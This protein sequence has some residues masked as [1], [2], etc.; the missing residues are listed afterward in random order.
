MSSLPFFVREKCCDTTSL[1][2]SFDPA[3]KSSLA[4]ALLRMIPTKGKVLI[5]SIPTPEIMLGASERRLTRPLLQDGLDSRHVNLSSL[6]TSITIVS[7]SLLCF[8]QL[9]ADSCFRSLPDP[10]RSVSPR[11][12]VASQFPSA[13][14]VLSRIRSILLSGS[15]RYN[16]S[17]SAVMSLSLWS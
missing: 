15:L 6:R 12:P 16:V 13:H 10:S 1:F 14:H 17:L 3:G 5:V 4:L 2:V 11:V 7:I 9:C 8:A